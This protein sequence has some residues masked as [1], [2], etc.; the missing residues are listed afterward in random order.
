MITKL[1]A[2]LNDEVSHL[3]STILYTKHFVQVLVH[4]VYLRQSLT[5]YAPNHTSFYI[6]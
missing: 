3:K 6:Y 2:K 4:C 5:I 1:E